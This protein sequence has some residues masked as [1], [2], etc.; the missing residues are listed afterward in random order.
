M[1]SQ[2]LCI[3]CR[4]SLE[5]NGDGTLVYCPHC[6]APQ[7]RLSEELCTQAEVQLKGEPEAVAPPPMDPAA[8]RWNS[9][10]VYSAVTAAVLCLFV[11]VLPPL[12]LLAP[13]IVLAVYA[14]RHRMATITTG[15]G[16]SVGLVCGVF[17]S[18]GLML[19]ETAGLL[20]LRLGTH[21]TNEFDTYLSNA[22]VQ[23]RAQMMA[24]GGAD[25]ARYI[26]R[27]M[28]VPEFRVGMFLAMMSF[29]VVVLMVA[30]AL[31]GALAGYLRRGP[32]KG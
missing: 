25:G 17:L 2:V 5:K 20:V 13:A 30:S 24:Q 14:A 21:G 28:T 8:T 27:M 15:L 18:L 19:M 1:V 7:V 12:A 6:G 29:V 9:L 22:L 31:S 23:T 10:I 32:R 16:A 26:D 11:V 3:R 4:L